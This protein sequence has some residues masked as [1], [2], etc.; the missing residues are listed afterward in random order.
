MKRPSHCFTPTADMSKGV[1]LNIGAQIVRVAVT[2]VL[3]FALGNVALGDPIHDAAR[4]GDQA[5]VIALLKQDPDLVSSKDKFG[6]TPLHL[7]A[8]HDQPAVAVL[9]LANGADVNAKNTSG[10]TPLTT[11]LL[12]YQHKE[13][14]ELL[15][16]H[17][18]DPNT[19]GVNPLGRAVERGLDYDVELLLANGADP[20]AIDSRGR[21]SVHWAV[22]NE[23]TQILEIL[24]KHGTNPNVKDWGGHT[25][26]YYAQNNVHSSH[27][28]SVTISNG[29]AIALLQAHGGHL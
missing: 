14:A 1:G 16:T 11:A 22:I 5:K 8:L 20:D 13:M 23:Q 21:M 24:L 10:E 17:G 3:C 18:A 27:F 26:M 6:N 7:A 15:L 4:K 19:A 29:K 2:A 28:T 12:S 25:P 9:L